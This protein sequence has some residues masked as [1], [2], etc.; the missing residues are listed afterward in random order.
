LFAAT[1]KHGDAGSL[2]DR[3]IE[4]ERVVC[5]QTVSDLSSANDCRSA[6]ELME[7]MYIVLCLSMPE[8]VCVCIDGSTRIQFVL[9]SSSLYSLFYNMIRCSLLLVLFGVICVVAAPSRIN[10]IEFTADHSQ[11]LAGAYPGK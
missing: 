8:S 2:V 4:T 7:N 11:W 1:A 10:S 9:Y 6:A 3:D 5:R